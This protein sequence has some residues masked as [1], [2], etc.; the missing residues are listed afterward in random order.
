MQCDD[1][2]D[3]FVLGGDVFGF[4]GSFLLLVYFMQCAVWNG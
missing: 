2:W 3:F 4:S 1:Y